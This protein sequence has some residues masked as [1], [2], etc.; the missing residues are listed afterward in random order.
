MTSD[1]DIDHAAKDLIYCYGEYARYHAAMHADE[2]FEKSD[3][4]GCARWERILKA[5]DELQGA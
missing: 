2:Q 4:D 3:L 5:V 1:N